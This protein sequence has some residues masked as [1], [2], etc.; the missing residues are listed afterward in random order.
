MN[1][2]LGELGFTLKV[3]ITEAWM[4][5]EIYENPTLV[6]SENTLK[7]SNF[8]YLDTKLNN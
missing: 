3:P 1:R 5:P 8:V 2:A 4:M 7:A 6:S